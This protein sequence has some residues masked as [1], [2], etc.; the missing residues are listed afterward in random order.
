MERRSLSQ[1]ISH[2]AQRSGVKEAREFASA[3]STGPGFRETR[4]FHIYSKIKLRNLLTDPEDMPKAGRYLRVVTAFTKA[5]EQICELNGSLLLEVQGHVHHFYLEQAEPDVNLLRRFCA[6]LNYMAYTEIE[7]IAGADGWGGFSCTAEYG[8]SVILNA[9][10]ESKSVISLGPCANNP[11]KKL[12]AGTDASTLVYRLNDTAKW[13]IEDLPREFKGLTKFASADQLILETQVRGASTFFR[14]DA[15]YEIVKLAAF[16]DEFSASRPFRAQGHFVRADL[17]GFTKRVK[18]ASSAN[19]ASKLKEL[20]IEI[21]QIV[22]G[23]E[24]ALKT[25]GR[26]IKL[27][28]WA[29]DCAN[30]FVFPSFGADFSSEEAEVPSD[31]SCYWKRNLKKIAPRYDWTIGAAG[32]GPRDLPTASHGIVLIAQING[33]RRDYLIAAGWGV[34]KSIKAQE[35]DGAQ[36]G[37]LV[38]PTDDFSVMVEV[39]KSSMKACGESRSYFHG[40][41]DCG[42]LMSRSISA[43]SVGTS[44]QAS[45]DLPKPNPWREKT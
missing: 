37:D 10:S 1:I 44:T 45:F 6:T 32:A 16:P 28:P 40:S 30:F 2:A 15:G 36:S 22:T 31:G 21:N 41:I 18:E 38:V 7:P 3:A 26:R 29:G 12:H 13:D 19:D 33:L 17:N 5:A 42:R 27:F 34:G 20:A 39:A 4:G 35:N 11:A 9:E 43:L 23:A 14:E 8:G 24:R 25:Y